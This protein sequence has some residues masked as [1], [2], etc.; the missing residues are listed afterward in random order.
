[1]RDTNEPGFTPGT[2]QSMT[3]ETVVAGSK[4]TVADTRTAV[5]GPQVTRTAVAG[6][7]A[8]AGTKTLAEGE[9]DQTLATAQKPAKASFDLSK[10]KTLTLGDKTY[11]I[12]KQLGNGGE[13]E[14]Y[15]LSLDGKRYALKL[16]RQNR[17]I[18]S[19]VISKLA[20]ISGKAAIADI[21]RYG[22]LNNN[23]SKRDYVLMDYCPDGSVA[24][25][26]FRNKDKDI[27]EIITL[28]A[29]NL[30]EL[31]K[32]GIV[33][34]DIKPEN[35][36]FTDKSNNML[37]ISDFGI[38]DI[39]GADGEVNTPQSRSP[40]YAA[41]EMYRG[42]NTSKID[43]VTYAIIGPKYDYYLLG[44]TALAMWMG[45][46]TFRK[47]EPELIK[48]KSRGRIDVPEAI[49]DP[50]RSIIRGLLLNRVENR[51]GY[52]EILRRLSGE[53]VP[54]SEDIENLH[55]VFDSGKG[56]IAR[57]AKELANMMMEDQEL[58]IDYLYRGY[59][60]QKLRGPMP[61]MEVRVNNVIE[62]QYPKNKLAGLYAA[63]LVLDPELPYYD[64]S[65]KI[66]SNIVSLC[67]AEDAFS[68]KI[69]EADN[70]VYIYL[71][72]K[73]GKKFTDEVLD[74]T[75]KAD[76]DYFGYPL[77]TFNRAVNDCE[78]YRTFEGKKKGDEAEFTNVECYTPQDV[79]KFCGDFP[80][81]ND[82]D[83]KY[84]CSLAFVEWL[85]IY[86]PED[87]AK[88][89]KLRVGHK[90]H[91]MLFRLIIQSLNPLADLNLRCDPKNPDYAMSGPAIGRLVN[92]AYDA[93]FVIFKRD[94]SAMCE[95][96][97]KPHNPYRYKFQASF[98]QEI[99]RS[100]QI[101]RWDEGYLHR[102]FA[103]KGSQF[104]RLDSFGRYCCTVKGTDNERKYG[105]YTTSIAMLKA[106]A[107]YG[108]K[109]EY[110]FTSGKTINSLSG[111]GSVMN[112]DIKTAFCNEIYAWLAVQYQEN[113][114]A[115]L[116]QKYA[117]ERLTKQ[118]IETIGRYSP[119]NK[120]YCRYRKALDSIGKIDVGRGVLAI[121]AIEYIFSTIVL[122]VYLAMLAILASTAIQ[123]P[124]IE[125]NS[126][127]YSEW[128][129]PAILALIVFLY[130]WRSHDNWFGAAI[131]YVILFFVLGLISEF[132]L[133]GKIGTL[134]GPYMVYVL[135]IPVV[136]FGILFGCKLLSPNSCGKELRSYKKPN[137]EQLVVEPL[138]F[139]FKETSDNFISSYGA[140]AGLYR[141][142]Y[143]YDV[144]KKI[145][146]LILSFVVGFF[147]L[148]STSFPL[149][150]FAPDKPAGQELLENYP[151]VY[152]VVDKVNNGTLF[153]KNTDESA[154]EAKP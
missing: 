17:P 27:L 146:P 138:H 53:N 76:N 97:Y 121:G 113:P 103:I 46:D 5:A 153:N 125:W 127:K 39:L 134:I 60:C 72:A 10:Q 11:K 26:D 92:Q 118:Y 106:A 80:V 116:S 12:E 122:L 16:Y 85:R 59:I 115:D 51:W 64:T 151:D 14:V 129:Q 123:Q 150:I 141:Q 154:E 7:T 73:Y 35:L 107:G 43:G 145:K 77:S 124:T 87:A 23:G 84:I 99:V 66:H 119:N 28:V 75:R 136:V 74:K 91:Q 100:F 88:I 52:D 38:A 96:W 8:V 152:E 6:G 105:P 4:T 9:G 15:R 102:F 54:I 149:E 50:L 13:A 78:M 89:E 67:K 81:V 44:M 148:I 55:V 24:D 22:S 135:M 36:L 30:N 37:V 61:E 128:L 111:L 33:H 147:L 49:P 101:D 142:W 34:K 133:H 21:R 2:P 47:A 32:A 41:P 45:T 57:T 40:I 140:N 93:Y 20:D 79:L 95:Y 18:N 29:R 90:N 56:K 126:A 25:Y 114:N 3:N 48:Q 83:M 1:M 109:V 131:K 144:K 120:R 110:R 62:R 63:A 143:G 104:N 31:H 19:K 86:S 139:T 137:F 108:H 112:N 65:G 98:A 94:S 71:R 42:T 132:S 69:T 130:F 68:E 117:Y 82:I 70:P 58:G